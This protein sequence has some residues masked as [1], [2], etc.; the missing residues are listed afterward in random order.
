MIFLFIL[1][2]FVNKLSVILIFCLIKSIINDDIQFDSTAVSSQNDLFTVI[3]KVNIR[4][5]DI[6]LESTRVLVDDGAYIGHLRSDGTFSVSGL[7][8]NSYVIEIS[9]P[10]NFFEPVRVDITSKGK[11]RAR[12]LN[13]IQPN[14]VQT[15]KYPL[16][17]ES[18]G[19]PN[20][21]LKR[22]QFLILDILLSPMVLMMVVPLLLVVVLPKLVNQDPEL[23]RELQQSPMLQPTQNMP[24]LGE[25]VTNFFAGNKKPT[26]ANRQQQR[27]ANH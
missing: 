14:D 24:D 13:L 7:P 22:E 9:S 4:P 17:F 6:D 16:N 8:S 1:R 25:M 11:I 10:K 21:F 20:Y 26:N 18:R 23:Q 5:E 2:H 15:L 3:G 27:R 12:R 19:Y